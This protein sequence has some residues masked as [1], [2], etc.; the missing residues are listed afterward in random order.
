MSRE[1]EIFKDHVAKVVMNTEDF[2]SQI[3]RMQMDLLIMRSDMCWILRKE[4]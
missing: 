2:F 4:S 3:G 1:R